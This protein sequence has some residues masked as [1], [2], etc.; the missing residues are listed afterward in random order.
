ME[1]K[2]IIQELQNSAT[3]GEEEAKIERLKDYYEK[4][5]IVLKA[6]KA[7]KAGNHQSSEYAFNLDSLIERESFIFETWVSIHNKRNFVLKT[8]IEEFSTSISLGEISLNR[9]VQEIIDVSS[10]VD[11][12]GIYHFAVEIND[13]YKIIDTDSV[14]VHRYLSYDNLKFWG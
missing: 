10:S 14:K 3:A 1:I 13:D 11:K 7:I 5:Q 4:T 8:N 6:I 2:E 12:E 9:L